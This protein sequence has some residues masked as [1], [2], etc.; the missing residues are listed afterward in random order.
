MPTPIGIDLG[1]CTSEITVFDNGQCKTFVD[2]TADSSPVVPSVVAYDPKTSELKVGAAAEALPDCI[3]E[4][5]RKMGLVGEEARCSTGGEDFTPEE[6]GSFILKHL[7]KI[8]E[9]QMFGETINDVILTVPAIFSE[10]ARVATMTAGQ[11]A[12]LNI[13]QLI[14]EPVAA[15]I[16]YADLARDKWKGNKTLFVFDF[17]GGT[18]DFSVCQKVGNV[19]NF[20]CTGGDAKLGGKDIDEMLMAYVTKKFVKDHPSANLSENLKIKEAFKKAS[21]VCKKSL[22]NSQN[23]NIYVGAFATKDG[24]PIDLDIVISRDEF[25]ERVLENSPIDGVDSIIKRIKV[26]LDN[27]FNQNSEKIDKKDIDYLLFVGGSSYIP[28]VQE[29][30]KKY[31]GIDGKQVDGKQAF[32]H[33]PNLAVSRGAAIYAADQAILN[34]ENPEE[35]GVQFGRDPGGVMTVYARSPH[36]IGCQITDKPTG[37][38]IYSQWFPPQQPIPFEGSFDYRLLEPDQTS[39]RFGVYQSTIDKDGQ[40]IEDTEFTGCENQ[41]VNIPPTTDGTCREVK[42]KVQYDKNGLLIATVTIPS[43]GQS[44]KLRHQVNARVTDASRRRVAEFTRN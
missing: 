36:G 12:G 24:E 38:H 8:A 28:Y 22:S 37:K 40:P 27:L 13:T 15:A 30:L 19:I 1:T 14:N 20:V 17:G 32:C 18:L 39:V 11:L 10:K 29:M 26:S 5:K 44:M 42:V 23:G 35:T 43:T 2:D 25:N 6:V 9:N 7:K 21:I 41:I 33:E 16:Y 34:S 4:A 31:L 3:R